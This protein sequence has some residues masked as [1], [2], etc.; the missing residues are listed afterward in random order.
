MAD[1]DS[2]HAAER[3]HAAALPAIAT[4]H[5]VRVPAYARSGLVPAIVHIGVGGFHRAHQGVYLDD[6]AQLTD[7]W[8][9]RGVGL[10][11]G[12]RRMADALQSQDGLYTVV[13]RSADADTARVVG[14]MLD[15]VFAPDDPER[16]F[17]CLVDPRTRI[18]TL[19]ITEDGYRVDEHT[20]LFDASDDFIVHDLERPTEPTT[21]FG[22]LT[23]ALERRRSGGLAPFSVLSCDNLPENGD[24]AKLA[25][26]SFARLR[27]DKL[28]DWIA[29]EVAFPNS[30]VDR[31][32][33][34]TTDADRELVAR[35]FGI[36]D[37]WPVMTEPFRQWV[38]E[39]TFCV[40]RPPFD[41]IE[42]GNARFVGD[43]RPYETWKLRLLNASHSSMAY[44][45]ALVG[46][47]MVHDVMA[48]TL[49]RDYVRSLM[50]DEVT[51]LMPAIPGEDLEQYKRD[52]VTRFANPKIGDQVVRLC[53]NGS[54]KFPKFITPSVHELRNRGQSC[55]LLTLSIAG[56]MRYLRGVD[57]HGGPIQIND[58][59]RDELQRRAREGRL[60]PRP[61]L[62]L[63]SIFGDL[64]DDVTFVQALGDTLAL[65]EEVGVRGALRQTLTAREDAS[66]QS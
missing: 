18:V 47:D 17:E 49:F 1:S 20:G 39:D 43:V 50:N 16:V 32:T 15:Y 36:R 56:W 21:V 31:I 42:G 10:L 19:T 37:A 41:A 53:L 61:L 52:L 7:A 34:Q 27:S 44:L 6:V 48:D 35:E 23:E 46:F 3:L 12:D 5:G 4:R 62:A 51:P 40:G 66:N 9:E 26:T 2:P 63:R 64:E 28:A 55:P 29:A 24:I 59:L 65:L 33:P 11:A 57:E 30:M 45:A 58:P 60:D 13:E 54:A 22:Y 38:I 25:I 14:S 8:G